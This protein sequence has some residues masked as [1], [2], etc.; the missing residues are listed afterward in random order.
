MQDKARRRDRFLKRKNRLMN[1]LIEHGFF[2][3]DTIM[4]Q[5]LTKLDPYLLRKKGLSQALTPEEFAR[6]FVKQ[7]RLRLT[8]VF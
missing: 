3:E 5:E 1:C 6:V 8:Q 2:P 4:R 7:I